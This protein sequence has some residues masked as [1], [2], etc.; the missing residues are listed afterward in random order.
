MVADQGLRG[1]HRLHEGLHDGVRLQG[2]RHGAEEVSRHGLIGAAIGTRRA[3]SARMKRDCNADSSDDQPSRV[4]A[5]NA[6]TA[7][8]AAG[9]HAARSRRSSPTARWR[10]PDMSLTCR[11]R[12]VP[13]PARPVGLR[14]VDGAAHH[15][16]PRRSLSRARSTGRVHASIPGACRRAISASCSRSRR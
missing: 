14:Q 8:A 2:R 7:Q 9:R 4:P 10:S 6:S 11:T 1:R 15:R 3:G 12:R 5:S 16:R 13:Q